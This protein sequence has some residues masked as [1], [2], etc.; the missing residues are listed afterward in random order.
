MNRPRCCLVAAALLAGLNAGAR[1]DDQPSLNIGGFGS[2]G[3]SYHASEGHEYRRSMD[4][5][6]GTRAGQVNAATDSRV[7]LQLGADTGHGVDAV[8]QGV[9]RLRADNNWR[10]DMT[11]AFVRLS[12]TPDWQFR[13]G[14]I[15]L[16]T[17]LQSDSR[18]IGFAFTPVRVLPELFAHVAY[19]YFDGVDITQKHSLDDVLISTNFYHG[20][21][22]MEVPSSTGGLTRYGEGR[23]SAL[24]VTLERGDWQG[25][26]H[27]GSVR[28]LD[29]GSFQTLSDG[30]RATSIPSAIRSAERIDFQG[31]YARFVGADLGY[32]S[33]PFSLE[34]SWLYLRAP[35]D[36][37][38]LTSDRAYSVLGSYRFGQFKPYLG[39]GRAS[40][41][42]AELE[43]GLPDIPALRE[44]RRNVNEINAHRERAQQ[45]IT[46]G[47]RYDINNHL[48]LKFQ[49]DQVRAK[50][51]RLLSDSSSDAHRY[52]SLTLW[53]S[54]LDFVF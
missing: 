4:Q 18:S 36:A 16:E 46:L 28:L 49:V 8:I 3:L 54:S 24:A 37:A 1:A 31:R 44:L 9:S 53:S 32:A 23:I 40:G 38:V 7:G 48:A 51:S 11:W 26:L 25:R 10:P 5:H 13:A 20:F 52:R 22:N 45:T 12:P 42:S 47:L 29:N 50:R 6:E 21:L 2:L 35:K 33:G 27:G 39:L 43:N 30:L 41:Q 15:G 17:R 14:R 19:E 34:A